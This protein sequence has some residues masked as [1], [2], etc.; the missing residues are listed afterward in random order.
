MRLANPGTD[1]DNSIAPREVF[2]EGQ[3]SRREMEISSH[4]LGVDEVAG[5]WS[6]NKRNELNG[7]SCSLLVEL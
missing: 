3:T 6:R 5:C 4:G 2:T 1:S 7:E